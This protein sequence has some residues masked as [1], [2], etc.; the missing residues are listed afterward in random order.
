MNSGSSSNCNNNTY[1]GPS[2]FSEPETQAV[3]DFILANNPP[4]GL[5][6]HSTFGAYL[7]AYGYTPDPVDYETYAEFSLD[8]LQDNEYPYGVTG[9]MLGY[10]SSGTTRDWMFGDQG[11]YG[12]TPEID[13]SG[14]WPAISEIIPLVNENI[15][16]LKYVAWIS[17]AYPD[18][19][20]YE[21]INSASL[22][23]GETQSINVELFNKGLREATSNVTLT[24][25]VLSNNASVSNPSI[26]VPDIAE[27]ATGD[28]G[29]NP[30]NI[31][32]DN[33]ANLGDPIELELVLEMEGVEIKKEYFQYFIGNKTNLAFENGEEGL[34]IFSFT[35]NGLPWDSSFVDSRSGRACITDSRYGNSNNSTN[36]RITTSS[37][38]LTGTEK[39]VLSFHAKWSLENG[40]DYTRVQVS[41][42]GGGSWTSLS[43][44]HTVNIQGGPGYTANQPWIQ[45][46]ID[47]SSYIGQQIQIR[48][49]LF[50]SN[51]IPG[52][53]FYLD[54]FDISDYALT[55]SIPGCTNADAHNYNPNATDDDGSCETCDD[56]IQNG[57]ETG[58]DCGG[59]L[60]VPCCT[61]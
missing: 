19:K 29:T 22:I 3:R 4:A 1:R 15:Q 55:V 44:I 27:R 10:T 57:D 23:P 47:L 25:N 42:N 35:G 30:F 7:Q 26:S 60:C 39:P 43:G 58:I 54:D 51:S 18:I 5:S 2:P 41:T 59:V 53:G 14:F 13:G 46:V 56:G 37:I 45:D 11:I 8:M 31:T 40:N 6:I 12:W 38:D 24:L 28:I 32:V 49:T 21:I 33:D 9:N 20:H 48:F 61:V 50:T 16:P 17:G 52:D 36:N 34:G